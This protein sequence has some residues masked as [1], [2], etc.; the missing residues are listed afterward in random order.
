MRTILTFRTLQRLQ[1]VVYTRF[2]TPGQSE[3]G[4]CI[5]EMSPEMTQLLSLNMS[6]SLRQKSSRVG[7]KSAPLLQ[8]NINTK[9]CTGMKKHCKAHYFLTEKLPGYPS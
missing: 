1:L 2:L 7:G 9:L 5:S 8:K 3:P 6:F 4:L